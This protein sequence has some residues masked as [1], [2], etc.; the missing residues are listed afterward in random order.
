MFSGIIER[1]SQVVSVNLEK[2]SH[3]LILERPD[4]F[5][6]IKAGDS[7]C[8]N[9]VCLTLENFTSSELAFTVGAE[10]CEVTRWPQILSKGSRLNIER[11]LKVSDRIHGHSVTG[12]VDCAGL[13][14]GVIRTADFIRIEVAVPKEF[15]RMVWLKGSIA[16]NGVSLTVNKAND[17]TIEVGLIP[18]TIIRTNLSTL[19]MGDLVNLEFDTMAKFYLRQYELGNV[20]PN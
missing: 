10:T 14:V 8:V 1:V 16:I 6:D 17:E 11:S 19:V 2:T 9:G 7:I 3:N 18:E 5:D 15:R 20:K 4:G 13:V 12:H